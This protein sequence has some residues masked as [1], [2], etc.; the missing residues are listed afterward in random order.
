MKMSKLN[1]VNHFEVVSDYMCEINDSYEILEKLLASAKCGEKA[2]DDAANGML[3]ELG[4]VNDAADNL[5]T[6]LVYLIYNQTTDL[7]GCDD[8]CAD[9]IARAHSCF[10]S[11]GDHFSVFCDEDLEEIE[12]DYPELFDAVAKA[13]DAGDFYDIVAA[14]ENCE[15]E[16]T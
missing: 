13:E 6:S 15:Y 12:D 5:F 10:I 8:P 1:F 3:Y 11:R 7:I 14:L 2:I 16:H 4:I 9:F